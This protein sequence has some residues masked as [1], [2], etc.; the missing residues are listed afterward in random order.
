MQDLPVPSRPQERRNAAH[1]STFSS[2][3]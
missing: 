1:S 2:R 3:I